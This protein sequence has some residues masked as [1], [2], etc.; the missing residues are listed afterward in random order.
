MKGASLIFRTVYPQISFLLIFVLQHFA[1]GFF[2]NTSL[3]FKWC[4]KC[5]DFLHLTP[6]GLGFCLDNNNLAD[7]NFNAV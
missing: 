4:H 1:D 7:Y 3:F 6:R 2:S 5:S